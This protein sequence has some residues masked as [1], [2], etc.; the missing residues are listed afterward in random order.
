MPLRPLT[1]LDRHCDQHDLG[2]GDDYDQDDITI[3]MILMIMLMI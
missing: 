2:H 1:N 3:G